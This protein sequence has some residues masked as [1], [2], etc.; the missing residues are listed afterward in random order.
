MRFLKLF[1]IKIANPFKDGNYSQVCVETGGLILEEAGINVPN[2][3]EDYG[4]VEF[5]EFLAEHGKRI[6]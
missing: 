6:R 1:G 2:S 5:R 4:L 3:L